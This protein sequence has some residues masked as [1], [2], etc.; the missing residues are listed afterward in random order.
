MTQPG[1]WAVIPAAGIGS[2][3]GVNLPKQYLP[4]GRRRV[5]EWAIDAFVTHPGIRGVVVCL[6]EDDTF[7][8][9]IA[10]AGAERIETTAGGAERCHSVRNG[11][12][13]V[14]DRDPGAWVLVHDAA[15]PCLWRN[16]LDRLIAEAIADPVGAIL[17]LPVRDTMKRVDADGRIRTTV[18]RADLWHALTPQMFRASQLLAALEQGIAAGALITDEAH[19]ME[20]S[21]QLPRIVSGSR[22]N[23]KITFPDDLTLAAQA[24]L[25][26]GLEP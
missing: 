21:G 16:D 14:V 18:D 25:A 7:W 8:P 5:I 22:D 9:E 2:R 19:A 24:L 1:L 3:M 17:A 20:L 15:R 12:R 10:L 23:L 4:L 11:V 13:F 6:A 26:R